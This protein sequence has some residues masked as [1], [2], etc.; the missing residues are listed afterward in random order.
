MNSAFKKLLGKLES[1]TTENR[2]TGLCLR[3]PADMPKLIKIIRRV[4]NWKDKVAD[5]P[6]Q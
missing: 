6:P 4:H 5:L 1:T 3:R 2:A